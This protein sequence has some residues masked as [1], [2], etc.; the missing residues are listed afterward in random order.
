MMSASGDAV[1]LG[2]EPTLMRHGAHLNCLSGQ[3]VCSR[4]GAIISLL[5]LL[6][7]LLVSLNGLS[8]WLAGVKQLAR[9]NN[10]YYVY[11]AYKQ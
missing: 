3:I 1:S 10:N 8:S 2:R 4:N 7:L 9:S 5:L 11:M 6:L